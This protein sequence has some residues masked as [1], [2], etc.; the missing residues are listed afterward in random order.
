MDLSRNPWIRKTSRRVYENAWIS[1]REDE[2]VRP[3]GQPGIY[4]VVEMQTWALGV[5]AL[6]DG[7][8]TYLVGQYRYPLELYSWEIPEGGGSPG[9][10]PLESASRELRE[11][12]GL[13]AERW[14]Y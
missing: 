13:T 8:Q 2:V 5:V 11:E 3:D 10:S 12:T 9:L 6:D 4:G 14:T 7:G 1:V